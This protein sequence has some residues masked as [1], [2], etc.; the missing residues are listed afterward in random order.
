MAPEPA[1]FVRA[2]F[3]GRLEAAAIFPYP[4]QSREQ[5]ETTEAI[6]ASVAE[7][8]ASAIDPARIDH[9][10]KIPASVI[11]GLRELGLFGLTIPEEFGGAGQ[12]QVT[13]ARVM[14]TV[15]ERCASTVTVLGAQ[16]GIGMKALLLYGTP[17]QK[18]H[19]LPRLASGERIAAFA[20]TEAGAGSDAAALATRAEPLADGSWRL[21]GRKIWITNGGI[22]NAF[23]V[24]ARTPDPARPAAKPH[25][26]PISTFWV[27]RERKGLSTGKPEDKLGLRGSSTT[28][29]ALEDVLVPPEALIGARGDGFK[30]ALNVLNSGRHGLAACCIGQAKLARA[31]AWKHAA[32]RVQFGRPIAHFGMV[33]ELLAGMDA[34]LYALEATTYLT[35]GLMDQG[36][37][38]MLEAAC[39]K[40]HATERLWQIVS[41]ALQVTGGTGFMRE[42][43]YERILRD[44]R[45]NMI[46]EGT[47]QVLRMM[48]A[49]QGLRSLQRGELAAALQRAAQGSSLSGVPASLAAEGTE[50][51]ALVPRFAASCQ[52]A[53]LCHGERVREAQFTLHRLADMVTALF[54]SAAVLARASASDALGNLPALQLDLARLACRRAHKD[55]ERAAHEEV[56]PDDEL[57]ERVAR[58]GAP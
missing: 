15:A 1:G 16:L 58:S 31:L 26:W 29:V 56:N 5:A 19:W 23:T 10:K 50:L 38:T 21:N 13:Y 8:A 53:L 27:E 39:C 43:P 44:A 36:R 12:G 11:D 22:A 35:A 49:H 24:F 47:N 45:I 37:E 52:A 40:L 25:E 18:A 51:E 32:E 54:V 33:Q 3:A 28:E 9:E 7:W 30:V 17:A 14:E 4:R 46:F 6:V 34:D 42:Y 55:F 41:D 48:I 57:I 20:L 2:L